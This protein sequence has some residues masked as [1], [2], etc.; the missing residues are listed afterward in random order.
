MTSQDTRQQAL[1]AALSTSYKATR[2]RRTPTP[3]RGGQLTDSQL[4]GTAC[5]WCATAMTA[6]DRHEVGSTGYPAQR[7]YGCARCVITNQRRLPAW[8]EPGSL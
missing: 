5:I 8:P 4:A 2:L 7:L 6:E 1:L 3:I